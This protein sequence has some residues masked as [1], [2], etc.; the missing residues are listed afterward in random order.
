MRHLPFKR[1]SNY[2][3]LQDDLRILNAMNTVQRACSRYG[4]ASTEHTVSVF[5]LDEVYTKY[6]EVFAK[7]TIDDIDEIILWNADRQKLEKQSIFFVAENSDLR[8]A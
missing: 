1:Q 5:N 6:A 7:N 8:I 2:S 3:W 4:Q